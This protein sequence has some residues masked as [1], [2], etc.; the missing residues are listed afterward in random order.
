MPPVPRVLLT[1]QPKWLERTSLLLLGLVLFLRF[2]GN[3]ML[4]KPYLMTF[5][6]YRTI[7][8]RLLEG[9]G[10]QLYDPTTSL[11][12][13]FKYSPLWAVLWIPLG[14]LPEHDGAVMWTALNLAFLGMALGLCARLCRFYGIHY[15]PLTAAPCRM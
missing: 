8:L 11:T 5:E 15:H 3:F 1:W 10:L 9:G 6:V 4:S 14:W 2:P 13:L 7:A 12:A